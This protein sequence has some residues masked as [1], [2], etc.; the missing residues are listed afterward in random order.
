VNFEEGRALLRDPVTLI[1]TCAWD[2]AV[3]DGDFCAGAG[4]RASLLT[5]L[6]SLGPRNGTTWTGLAHSRSAHTALGPYRRAGADSRA[7]DNA[8]RSAGAASALSLSPQTF[9]CA[10]SPSISASPGP[11]RQLVRHIRL[12]VSPVS[13]SHS[14]TC[15]CAFCWLRCQRGNTST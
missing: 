9:S 7:V 13:F 3:C 10:V 14:T 1:A 11:P 2:A 6:H 8:L 15:P 12:L 5:S 4:S